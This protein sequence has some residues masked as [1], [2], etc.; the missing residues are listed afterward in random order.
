M[1]DR[2]RSIL[3]T[4]NCLVR[5]KEILAILVKYGY[6]DLLMKINPSENKD[7]NEVLKDG[8]TVPPESVQ[9]LSGAERFRLLLESLG[10]TFIKFGQIL[11]TRNDILPEDYCA[12]LKKLQDKVPPFPDEQAKAIIKEELGKTTDELFQSFSEKPVA[13]ASIAQVYKATLPSGEIVAIKIRRPN[14]EKRIQADLAIMEDLSRLLEKY[15]QEARAIRPTTLV[16][17]F[18]RQLQQEMNLLVEANNLER[19][20]ILNQNESRLKLVKLYRDLSTSHILTMEFVTGTKISNTEKLR[21]LNLDLKTIAKNGASVIISQIFDQ[22]FYHGDPHPG[23]IL[24]QDDGRICFLDFGAM[25]KLTKEQRMLLAEGLVAVVRRRDDELLRVVLKLSSNGDD[26]KDTKELGRDISDF[27]DTYAYLP[28]NR[29]K[30]DE[31]LNDLTKLLTKHGIILPPEISTLVKVLA[32]LDGTYLAIDPDFQVMEVMKPYAQKLVL[33]KFDP[34]RLASDMTHTSAELYRL[35]RDLPDEARDLIKTIKKAEI[36]LSLSSTNLKQVLR[37]FD[38]DANRLSYALIVSALLLASAL[39]L[40]TH[41][42]P[43]WHEVSILGIVGLI[44][45]ATMG[46]WLLIAIA[47]SGHL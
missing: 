1:P 13:C 26:I 45:S 15:V 7:I 22:G 35:L 25:G 32:M 10:T 14:I 40:H 6:K 18:G 9:A 23:N 44:A 39:L 46:L 8:N 42:P 47:R 11:S 5:Y 38:K 33:E 37:T 3:E 29:I 12:E 20:N 30:V 43:V 24:V 34:K 41:T 19:F 28:L 4:Y 31:I 17:E 36:K 2:S 27:V 16:R 21:S